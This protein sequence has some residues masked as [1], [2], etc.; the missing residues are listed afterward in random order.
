MSEITWI[1]SQHD[2][3]VSTLNK[4]IH[5]KDIRH[6]ISKHTLGF[7]NIGK[8]DSHT[9]TTQ[10][11]ECNY[12]TCQIKYIKGLTF[13]DFWCVAMYDKGGGG[14]P[15]GWKIEHYSYVY[16]GGA[17]G[18]QPK[19][20]RDKIGFFL[21]YDNYDIMASDPSFPI[22]DMQRLA[23]EKFI[24]IACPDEW[25]DKVNAHPISDSSDQDEISRL[26]MIFTSLSEHL[27]SV[28]YEN[29]TQI[30]SI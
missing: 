1:V 27:P 22:Y 26:F 8:L 18:V 28:V 7:V 4:Y 14:Y 12:L 17:F 15:C 9:F 29:P 2:A 19:L 23:Q 25:I 11:F 30:P 5:V 10:E 21:M 6:I 24:E 3:V 20:Y 16:K 13:I